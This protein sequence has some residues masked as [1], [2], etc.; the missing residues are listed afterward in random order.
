MEEE[1]TK[2]VFSLRGMKGVNQL[3]LFMLIKEYYDK[4]N[5]IV[6]AKVLFEIEGWK[7]KKM[8]RKLGV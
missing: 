1:R 8:K 2:L 7:Y 4:N 3:P 6:W 5:E